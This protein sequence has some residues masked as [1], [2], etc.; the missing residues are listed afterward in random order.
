MVKS[1][2]ATSRESRSRAWWDAIL[3]SSAASLRVMSDAAVLCH[4]LQH[5]LL[6]LQRFEAALAHVGGLCAEPQ[7]GGGGKVPDAPFSLAPGFH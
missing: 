4:V 5:H 6:L 7:V 2:R 1:P 3:H